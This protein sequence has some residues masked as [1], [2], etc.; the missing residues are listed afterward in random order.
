MRFH[1]GSYSRNSPW[2]AAPDGHGDGIVLAELDAASGAMEV[3]ARRFDD[4]PAYIVN[5]RLAGRLWTVTEAEHGGA[6]HGYEVDADGVLGRLESVD[7]GA[8]APCHVTVDLEHELAYAAHY[9]GA[10]FSV[11][12]IADGF[13][14]A[15]LGVHETPTEIAGVDRSAARSRPHSSIVIGDSVLIA[16]C[17]RDSLMLYAIEG[18]GR[19]ARLTLLDALALPEGTG[20]RHL[21]RSADAR[22]VYV[23][24]QNSPGVSVVEVDGPRL[25]LRQIVASPGLGRA[26]ALASE[27]A[28]HPHLP[29]VYLANRRD[30]SISLFDVADD[31][32]RL[33]WRSSVDVLGAWPRHFQLTP[34]GA[35]LLVANQNS[36]EVVSF[37]AD[38]SGDLAWTGHR[39]A[40]PTPTMIRA[41]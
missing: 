33:E 11:L 41:W 40:L 37:A 13:P 9:Q 5:D 17:G 39:L 30:E 38:A 24:N 35:F 34:D 1:V 16:D 26:S 36:N 27:I 25:V 7:T 4:N 18:R 6:L 31:D 10:R 21:A 8:D 19:D 20:P 12:S 32:G 23:S 15:L 28:V 29:L 22:T 2:A 14:D 3:V